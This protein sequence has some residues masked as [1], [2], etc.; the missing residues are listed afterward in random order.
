MERLISKVVAGAALISAT[1]LLALDAFATNR[2][3]AE[4][5]DSY[6]P[7]GSWNVLQAVSE[8]TLGGHLKTGHG[9]TGQNRPPGEASETGDFY[10][11]A[12]S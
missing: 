2:L 1:N 8:V 12:T 4:G 11:A 6:S 5:V 7:C 9:W 10:P 3:V